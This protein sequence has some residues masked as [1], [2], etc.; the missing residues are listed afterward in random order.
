EPV[1]RPG[2]TIWRWRWNP[3]PAVGLHRLALEEERPDGGAQLAAWALRVVTHKIDQ[4]RYEALLEDIQ[5]AA[6][7][8]VSTLA[9]AGAEGAELQ[10]EAPWRHSPAEEYYAL[11]EERLASFEHAARRI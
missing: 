4:E 3:G 6:Y 10:R 9:G 2:E 5:R 1:L 7:G 11:F 8:L